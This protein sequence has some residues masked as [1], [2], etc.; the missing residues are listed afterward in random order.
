MAA[1]Y[2]LASKRWGVFTKLW[3]IGSKLKPV[4]HCGNLFHVHSHYRKR[5]HF[6]RNGHCSSSSSSRVQPQF[7]CSLGWSSSVVS[8]SSSGRPRLALLSHRPLAPHRSRLLLASVENEDFLRGAVSSARAWLHTSLTSQRGRDQ[9][10]GH[11]SAR[12]LLQ[13]LEIHAS[14]FS[15]ETRE[16]TSRE[17]MLF[18]LQDAACWLHL[19]FVGCVVPRVTWQQSEVC[20]IWTVF[21]RTLVSKN[22]KKG[23]AE[24][25]YCR[26]SGASQWSGIVKV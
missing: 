21:Q 14:S 22:T 15:A 11:A 7:L 16:G 12:N 24:V 17:E 18:V 3:P 8:A 26:A 10:A 2:T 9:C 19:S 13:M 20:W 23:K 4:S 25:L 6:W 1:T 5:L